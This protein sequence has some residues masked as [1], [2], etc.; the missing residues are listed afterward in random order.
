MATP[1]KSYSTQST[2]LFFL[3]ETA[4]PV[5][6]SPIAAMTGF[7]G[8]GGKKTKIDITNYDS[9][10]YKEYAGG[11]L[12]AGELSFDLIWNFTNPNHILVMTLSAAANATIP[13]FYGASDSAAV[14]T[15]TGTLALNTTVMRAPKSAS[16]GTYSRSGFLFSGYFSMFQVDA[17]VDS[18]IK[19]KAAVQQT[20]G[21]SPIV[22]GAV[23]VL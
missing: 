8:L 2:Q 4:S 10:G 19:V 17:P 23:E 18:V 1:T 5:L 14:P 3:N 12:D 21:I 13:F 11:L 9:A 16:P 6:A 7:T 15:V 22:L 20:G